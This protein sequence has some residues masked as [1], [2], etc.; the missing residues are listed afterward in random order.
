MQKGSTQDLFNFAFSCDYKIPFVFLLCEARGQQQGDDRSIS[1]L[2]HHLV[3]F[4]PVFPFLEFYGP[5]SPELCEVLQ[6][7]YFINYLYGVMK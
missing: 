2:H 5:P 1:Q 7:I 3:Y 6:Y 4:S